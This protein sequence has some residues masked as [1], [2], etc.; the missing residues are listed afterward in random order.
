MIK[1]CR[2]AFRFLLL[3][4][5]NEWPRIENE[6]VFGGEDHQRPGI[7]EPHRAIERDA[8]F[9]QAA[10]LCFSKPLQTLKRHI[11][12]SHGLGLIMG[13]N[14]RA[15]LAGALIID[16]TERTKP[17]C[18]KDDAESHGF[19]YLDTRGCVPQHTCRRANRRQWSI[20]VSVFK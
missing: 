8:P 5:C 3:R 10:N 18:D 6:R 13:S 16:S 14:K 1:C 7:T 2:K 19:C 11:L 20:H 12:S 17:S 15:A 9:H 4:I